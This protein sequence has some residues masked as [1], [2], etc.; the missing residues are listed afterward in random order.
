MTSPTKP[1]PI[2]SFALEGVTGGAAKLVGGD[3]D[4]GDPPADPGTNDL[5]FGTTGDDKLNGGAG[6]DVIFAN[7]GNDLVTVQNDGSDTVFGNWG[8]DTAVVGWR[9]DGSVFHGG[10]GNDVLK[11]TFGD[12][13]I[14]GGPPTIDSTTPFRIE[15]NQMIFE[16][17][18]S[19]SVT[20]AGMTIHFT[21]VEV[22]QAHGWYPSQD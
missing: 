19:G 5:I 12:D 17:P 13:A 10:P 14:I 18:A 1:T 9:G 22:V 15:G 3:L 7:Q 4:G 2:S 8:D 16:G 6:S 20:W 21:D 11:L